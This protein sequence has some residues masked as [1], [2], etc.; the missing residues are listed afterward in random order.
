[1]EGDKLVKILS[2][3][4]IYLTLKAEE[5]NSLCLRL[6]LCM[7]TP[8]MEDLWIILCILVQKMQL[9]NVAGKCD[10]LMVNSHRYCLL[11]GT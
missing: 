11:Q 8:P 2:G 10:F 5:H 3:L 9:E 1:M 4:C 7:V 6:T